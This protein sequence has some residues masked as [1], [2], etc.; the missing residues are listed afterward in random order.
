MT[1]I[2]HLPFLLAQATDSDAPEPPAMPQISGTQVAIF[3][4]IYLAFLIFIIAGVWKTFA[5]AG[6]PGW[7]SLIPIYNL[8]II[9]VIAK[10]D[11]WWLILIPIVN[12]V[13][14]FIL[15]A[16][17]AR[18]YG[19]GV[20]FGLGLLFLGFIFFPILGFGSARYRGV[21]D[22]PASAI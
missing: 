14:V 2:Y 19:K 3:S 17:F 12:F 4:I 1:A 16:A 22:L 21:P 10:K 13:Y 15:M 20:G 7:A 5:K 6:Q 11:N 8:Y 18:Q 9:G